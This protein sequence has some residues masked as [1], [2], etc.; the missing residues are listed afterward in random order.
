LRY[1]ADLTPR[2]SA[3]MALVRLHCACCSMRHG[4]FGGLQLRATP[5]HT[6]P[7]H[8]CYTA[9]VPAISSKT[10][11]FAAEPFHKTLARRRARRLGV[12]LGGERPQ[13]LDADAA[14]RL[15]RAAAGGGEL[16]VCTLAVAVRLL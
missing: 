6:C 2:E 1:A 3:W 7:K 9:L 10:S 8:T 14:A 12:E 13:I 15:C 16:S 5:Y 11:I 4:E